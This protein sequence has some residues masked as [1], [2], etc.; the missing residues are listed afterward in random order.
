MFRLEALGRVLV[1]GGGLPTG[2]ARV[3]GLDPAQAI[4]DRA[5]RSPGVEA[6]IVELDV[7]GPGGETIAVRV[8]VR[9]RT[10]QAGELE[11]LEG[12]AWDAADGPEEQELFTAL[13]HSSPTGIYV[14]QDGR[15]VFVNEQMS[16]FTRYENGELLGMESSR[17][18]HPD[19]REAVRQNAVAMLKGQAFGSY[20]Y[21]AISRGG[22]VRWVLE[23]VAPVHYRQRR[24]TL[25]N[26]MDITRQKQLEQRLADGARRDPLTSL[27]NRTALA[28]RL[29]EALA[30]R[31]APAVLFIDLD[32][33][34]QVN[35]RHG[36]AAGDGLL[37]IIAARIARA[38]RP[39]DF[40]AR[41]GGDEFVVVT[42]SS[43]QD[44]LAAIA[45][46]VI[47]AVSAPCELDGLAVRVGASVGIAA[48]DRPGESSDRLI[49]RADAAMYRAKADGPCR[50]M[51]DGRAGQAA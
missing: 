9:C 37:K 16:R 50:Y 10:G 13:T 38:V 4:G 40:V 7:A 44:A 5:R 12:V 15:F 20:E 21:R 45:T 26:Y 2:L 46:R 19:D 39:T 30:G 34:K 22:T 49:A 42:P 18:V 41:V 17:L 51:V 35:D 48:G 1:P 43:G 14:V 32:D 27:P 29:D 28:E 33:F 8:E 47:D 3:L 23:S 24:A 6:P 36:H 11:V 31:E 25:G